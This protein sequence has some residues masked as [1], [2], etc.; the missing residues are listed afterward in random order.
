[1]LAKYCRWNLCHV[2]F[3]R[4]QCAAWLL[5]YIS[6]DISPEFARCK[7]DIFT[8]DFGELMYVP[9]LCTWEVIYKKDQFYN[10]RVC[11]E[12]VHFANHFPHAIFNQERFLC[13]PDIGVQKLKCQ[14]GGGKG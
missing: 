3:R 12:V 11:S 1:M 13:T 6:I 5:E 4:C 10:I 7:I 2:V 8:H 14:E 9:S